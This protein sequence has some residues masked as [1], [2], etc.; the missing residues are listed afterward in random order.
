MDL[1]NDSNCPLGTWNIQLPLLVLHEYPKPGTQ[2]GAHECALTLTLFIQWFW[3]RC[4]SYFNWRLPGWEIRLPEGMRF[5]FFTGR[6]YIRRETWGPGGRV[7]P[8]CWM[9]QIDCKK[10]DASWERRSIA[11]E[12]GDKITGN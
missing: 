10:V 1:S 6:K 5:G 9:A 4:I 7:R 2:I 12:I 11:I 3:R 8:P